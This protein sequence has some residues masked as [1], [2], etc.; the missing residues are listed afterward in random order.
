MTSAKVCVATADDLL[1]SLCECVLHHMQWDCHHIKPELVTAS[2]Q[3]FD[4]LLLDG[5]TGLLRA[6]H[7]MPRA[8]ARI[9]LIRNICPKTRWR[10]LEN[11]FHDYVLCPFSG[12]ELQRKL[13]LALK[14]WVPEVPLI[15]V[16]PWWFDKL[17]MCLR[18]RHQQRVQQLSALE[19]CVLGKLIDQ[20]PKPCSVSVLVRALHDQGYTCSPQSVPSIVNKLRQRIEPS[21]R[22]AIYLLTAKGMGYWLAL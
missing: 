18:H 6:D 1:A 20:A 9:G 14:P 5:E 19:A 2:D 8:N 3:S 10:L 7:L 13:K 12:E 11:G 22:R 16:G 4:V 17:R 21:N 15:A